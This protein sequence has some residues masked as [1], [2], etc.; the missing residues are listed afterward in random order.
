MKTKKVTKKIDIMHVAELSKLKLTSSEVKLFTLQLGKIIEHVAD[1]NEVDTKDSKPTSQTTGLVNVKR[2][3]E[4]KQSLSQED[5]V[6]QKRHT[7]NGYF[8]V[9]MILEN[10]EI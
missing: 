5:A 3:D 9:P 8:V 1:L 6:S 4:V 10:K 7:H 2:K